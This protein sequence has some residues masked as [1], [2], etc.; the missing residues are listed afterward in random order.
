M[1]FFPFANIVNPDFFNIFE[2]LI[3]I[4]ALK[5]SDYQKNDSI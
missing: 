4:S 3:H 1:I 2:F 5:L